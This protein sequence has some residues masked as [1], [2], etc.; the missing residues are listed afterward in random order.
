[1]RGN[2]A[3]TTGAADYYY[4]DA[5]GEEV[6]RFIRERAGGVGQGRDVP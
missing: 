5:I 4:N 2:T 3:I 6:S 1:L